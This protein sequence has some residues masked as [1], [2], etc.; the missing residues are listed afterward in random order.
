MD[1]EQ[2]ELETA[3]QFHQL[4][5][6][7]SIANYC[8]VLYRNIALN[9]SEI[10]EKDFKNACIKFPHLIQAET[11][12]IGRMLLIQLHK[13][14]DRHYKSIYLK[15]I[16]YQCS[17]P[18]RTAIMTKFDAIDDSHK[19]NIKTLRHQVYAHTD[20]FNNPQKVLED[21]KASRVE[22]KE[23]KDAWQMVA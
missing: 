16:I 11:I 18:E 20:R 15:D 22:F 2:K 3:S 8:F 6:E 12:I 23:V 21:I 14:F 17:E 13:F 19:E 1:N 10:D 9:T 7:L 5:E 4:D